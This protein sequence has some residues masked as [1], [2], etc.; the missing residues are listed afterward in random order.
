MRIVYTDQIDEQSDDFDEVLIETMYACNLSIPLW[1]AH[2]Q[3]LVSSFVRL[4]WPPFD[5]ELIPQKIALLLTL[6]P[7]SSFKIRCLLAVHHGQLIWTI[8]L[9]PLMQQALAVDITEVV[10]I[11][12][13]LRRFNIKSKRNLAPIRKL[14]ASKN[15]VM[16]KE[17]LLCD[18][19]GYCLEA[20]YANIFMIKGNDILTPPLR[21]GLV[22]GVFRK[23]ILE[24]Q[25]WSGYK[26]EEKAIH[27]AN[28]LKD[29]DAIFLTNAVRGVIPV[30]SLLGL[31]LDIA[32]A[33][34]LQKELS[35]ELF[36]TA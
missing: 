30:K 9:Q 29:A 8:Q 31:P 35:K 1:E 28:H 13:Y 20:T 36:K 27:F 11:P 33:Q 24:Q 34:K 19:D 2:K 10:Y 22:S 16:E 15:I 12:E 4:N 32:T 6:Y 17:V 21:Q 18:V 23:K 3:R 7:Y 5:F 14:R 26:I 25:T